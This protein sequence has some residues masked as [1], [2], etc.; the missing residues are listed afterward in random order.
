MSYLQQG[1]G[2]M[3]KN[4]VVVPEETLFHL[5]EWENG[6]EHE[7][8]SIS[9]EQMLD[10]TYDIEPGDIHGGTLPLSLQR[11]STLIDIYEEDMYVL[12]EDDPKNS[13]SYEARMLAA[14]INFLKIKFDLRCELIY[15]EM[16]VGS[17]IFICEGWQVTWK[18]YSADLD[19]EPD[20]I[21]GQAQP[22]VAESLN[23]STVS[24]LAAARDAQRKATKEGPAA[25]GTVANS[26]VVEITTTNKPPQKGDTIH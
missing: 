15:P 23:S 6:L 26:V 2:G 9:D 10:A 8:E 13:G 5:S 22:W 1:D 21:A 16:P 17:Q 12:L 7:I 20:T 25:K 3:R 19:E 4:S 18:D 24:S 14:K 11:L